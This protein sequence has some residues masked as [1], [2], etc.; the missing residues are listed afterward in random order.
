MA[1]PGRLGC[2]GFLLAAL[3]MATLD[4]RS[5]RAQTQG[6]AVI[7]IAGCR[8]CA[9][10]SRPSPGRRQRSGFCLCR[11]GI[12]LRFGRHEHLVSHSGNRPADFEW[13][14]WDVGHVFDQRWGLHASCSRELPCRNSVGGQGPGASTQLHV[15][16]LRNSVCHA[17]AAA[18][19][20]RPDRD[21]GGRL[22]HSPSSRT[23]GAHRL[24]REP[25][26]TLGELHLRRV[27]TR[28]P[29]RNGAGRSSSESQSCGEETKASITQTTCLSSATSLSV[30]EI[31][32]ANTL[33]VVTTSA[34]CA[35]IGWPF[36]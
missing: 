2:S 30:S 19:P 18:A 35:L 15:A 23:P 13:R 32:A 9:P 10:R 20:R 31:P 11:P 7:G 36:N 14:T 21:P 17:H 29:P 12:R 3:M 26:R 1:E 27:W 6:T 16:C 28:R 24:A 22:G 33:A 5:A 4:C 34:S 25:R 8:R